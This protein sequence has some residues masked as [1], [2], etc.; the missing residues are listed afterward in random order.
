MGTFI[1]NLYKFTGTQLFLEQH[2][3]KFLILKL[4]TNVKK[5]N[6]KIILFNLRA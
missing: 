5:G 2:K 6:T 4:S 3:S 1:F